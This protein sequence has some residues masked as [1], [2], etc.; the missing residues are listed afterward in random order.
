MTGCLL[1]LALSVGC[2]GVPVTAAPLA[3]PSLA[4]AP[5]TRPLQAVPEVP[6]D[7]WL[8]EDKLRHFALSFAATE[9]VYAGSSFGLDGDAA[10]PAAAATGLALGI[11]K[12][13]RD[14]RAGLHFCLKDLAWDAAGV[15]LGVVLVRNIP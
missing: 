9:M 15:A 6:A 13:L 5:S 12:E 3:A 1:V 10:L 7:R 14:R 8:G 4:A 2:P 11:A